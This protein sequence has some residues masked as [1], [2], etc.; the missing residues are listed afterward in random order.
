MGNMLKSFSGQPLRVLVVWEPVLASDREPP[1][2]GAL[3]RI[4][5]GRA[6]QFWDK[7]R[8]I[9]HLMG[10]HDPNSVVFDQIAVY[11][12]GEMWPDR[13]PQPL[14]QGGRV[15]QVTQAARAAI[16]RA[17]ARIEPHQQ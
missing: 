1:S 7:S 12:P 16:A 2:T 8:L 3:G 14:F 10:E 17:L 11:P 6:S 4:P 5:D 13:P 9:S 15:A